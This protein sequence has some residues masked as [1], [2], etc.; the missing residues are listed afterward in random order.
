MVDK[1]SVIQGQVNTANAS[2]FN[3]SG[4][5]VSR[6]SVSKGMV[7]GVPVVATAVSVPAM[8]ASGVEYRLEWGPLPP[9][10]DSGDQ[11][12]TNKT[13]SSN[14]EDVL[15]LFGWQATDN[16]SSQQSIDDGK[17][18]DITISDDAYFDLY[19]KPV[20]V[21]GTFQGGQI[22][23]GTANT[24]YP[25]RVKDDVSWTQQGEFRLYA[26]LQDD[27][28]IVVANDPTFYK[29]T[30]FM[31]GIN[32]DGE[33]GVGDT[34]NRNVFTR[35]GAG[36]GLQWK[37]VDSGSHHSVGITMDGR[38]YVWGSG[39]N[40]RLGLGSDY[41][42]RLVPTQVG[43]ATNWTLCNAGFAHTIAVNNNGEAYT[44]GNNTSG[45]LGLGTTG[46][47]HD[48]PQKIPGTHKWRAPLAGNGFS[49]LR[50][51]SGKPYSF[52]NNIYG[53]LGLGDTNPRNTLT[54]LNFSGLP[55][56]S[57]WSCSDSHVLMGP[58][59]NGPLFAWGNNDHG[60]LGL[61]TSGGHI[62]TLTKIT[63]TTPGDHWHQV[64]AGSGGYS[65]GLT[66]TGEVYV[67]GNIIPT[68]LVL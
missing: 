53:Q 14:A 15:T 64:S 50:D 68:S 40:G 43:S 66:N 1:N 3:D 37:Q 22:Q 59:N 18:A 7:W 23:L 61:G 19:G 56:S 44:W 29:T 35:V 30:L 62:T 5:G 34:K 8:A 57:I 45:E 31:S 26:V 48:A 10:V 60:Q 28:S 2:V 38:L 39:G 17:Q 36:L 67:W 51:D 25:I 52:G 42:N 41:S 6:R 20:A 33:L 54:A 16:W 21:T 13:V 55:T 12:N 27:V 9:A 11:F 65:I 47:I 4:S 63:T 46:G 32:S 24:E 49:F 58:Q